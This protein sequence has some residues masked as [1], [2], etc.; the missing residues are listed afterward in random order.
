MKEKT[1]NISEQLFC[2]IAKLIYFDLDD[3]ELKESVK[4]GIEKKFDRMKKR[5]EYTKKICGK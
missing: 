2:N 5:E 4:K 1:I 3:E